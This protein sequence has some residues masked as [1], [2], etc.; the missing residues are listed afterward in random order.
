MHRHSRVIEEDLTY[1]FAKGIFE[2]LQFLA[3]LLI[4]HLVVVLVQQPIA[5]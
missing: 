4:H 2:H 5:C 1:L 3:E